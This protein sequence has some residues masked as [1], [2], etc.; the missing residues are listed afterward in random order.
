MILKF[1]TGSTLCNSWRLIDNVATFEVF[2]VNGNT[3]AEARFWR[4]RAYEAF[5]KWKDVVSI[6]DEDEK[7]NVS[8]SSCKR[9]LTEGELVVS[10][11]LICFDCACAH[12]L[13]GI[14]KGAE[15]T[16]ILGLPPEV[17]PIFRETMPDV[18]RDQGNNSSIVNFVMYTLCGDPPHT[19][20]TAIL[21]GLPL[22]V[23]NDNG[24]TVEH[25][26]GYR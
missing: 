16:S 17:Q 21:R 18:Y 11:K 20:H 7:N 22:F 12:E 10:G 2:I 3:E 14:Q 19:W 23:L 8:C 24:K 9:H 13:D 1:E 15:E 26:K 5:A 4:E 6:A 25:F